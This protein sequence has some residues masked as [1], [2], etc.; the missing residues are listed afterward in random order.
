MVL[1]RNL[2]IQ[3]LNFILSPNLTYVGSLQLIEAARNAE[4]SGASTSLREKSGER[5]GN[6]NAFRNRRHPVEKRFLFI[7]LIIDFRKR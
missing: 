1:A 7:Y 3:S 5:K 6:K 4:I 2:A